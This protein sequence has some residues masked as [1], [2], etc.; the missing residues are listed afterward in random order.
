[1]IVCIS[2]KS[3]FIFWEVNATSASHTTQH[4]LLVDC[5]KKKMSLN[6]I[7]MKRKKVN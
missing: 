5:L 2:Q 6:W 7:Q 3:S 4:R 1:M